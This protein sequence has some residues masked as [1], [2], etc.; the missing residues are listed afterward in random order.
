MNLDLSL[1][2][3][4]E[5]TISET[6]PVPCSPELKRKVDALKKVCGKSVNKK[7]RDFMWILVNEH[8]DKLE[9]AS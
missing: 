6:L 5:E 4:K 9:K 8:Q 2:I 1:N 3:E 7:I